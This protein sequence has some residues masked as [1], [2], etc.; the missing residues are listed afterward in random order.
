MNNQIR[1]YELLDINNI[2]DGGFQYTLPPSTLNIIEDLVK[3]VGNP[4]YQKTP[5]FNMKKKNNKKKNFKDI[6]DEDWITIRQFQKTNIEKQANEMELL[7]DNI[8]KCLNKI[9][10][11][12]YDTIKDEIFVNIND[13]FII[14]NNE[15]N[16]K[17]IWNT[18]YNIS[19]SNNFH[20]EIYIRLIKEIKNKYKEF[21]TFLNEEF[22]L[23]E[24]SFLSNIIDIDKN[25]NDLTYEELCS[26]N[27]EKSTIESQTAFFV[28][29]LMHELIEEELLTNLL[30]DLYS[31]F[32]NKIKNKDTSVIASDIVHIIQII[33]KNGKNYFSEEKIN[34]IKET[35]S[36]ILLLNR[37]DNPGY[38]QKAKFILMDLESLLM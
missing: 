13:S 14:E 28:M 20:L 33:I 26:Y 6:P 19:S 2:I 9:T 35:T 11:K 37:K 27:L 10:E 15:N 36:S 18:I 1:R 25:I 12:T 34:N 5:I 29:C 21:Q 8:K 24:K 3:E 38:T 22:N 32:L 7:L 16:L 30:N 17:Q 4:D 23:Y 31:K